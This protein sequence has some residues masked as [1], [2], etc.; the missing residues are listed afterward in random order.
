MFNIEDICKTGMTL[1]GRGDKPS[2][3][4]MATALRTLQVILE[5]WATTRDVTFWNIAENQVSLARGDVAKVGDNYYQC[6]VNHIADATN[7]PEVG[8]NYLS[9]WK[10]TSSTLVYLTWALGNSYLSQKTLTLTEINLEDAL[11]LQLQCDS[12]MSGIER[13]TMLEFQ[14]LDMTE[15]GLPTKCWVQKTLNGLILNFHP[16]LN[17]DEAKIFYY[18]INRPQPITAAES[19][20]MGGQ[21]VQAAYY[22]L[23]TELG[24]LYN[25]NLERLD[26]LGQKAAFE[27]AKALRTNTSEVDKCFVKPCY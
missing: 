22:A 17:E 19:T 12:Q 21:W 9:Y 1:A 23:A 5:D 27:L 14:R 4:D 7:Q 2:S 6:Y 15:L 16:L 20:N 24:F 25:I 26:T 10:A 8:A 18:A 3:E 13:I 11:A